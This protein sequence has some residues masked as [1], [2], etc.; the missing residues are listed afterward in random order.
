MRTVV[1]ECVGEIYNK[2]RS[3]WI[4]SFA[5]SECGGRICNGDGYSVSIGAPE[6]PDKWENYVKENVRFCPYCGAKVVS[7]A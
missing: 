4:R 1:G 5:C 3:L 7:N 2:C 6:E